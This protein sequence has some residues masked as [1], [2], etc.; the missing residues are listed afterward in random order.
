MDVYLDIDGVL[1]ANDL[2]AAN[3]ANEFL[4]YVLTK[5]P[6]STY[7]LTTHCNGDANTP[8][9]HVGHL[10]KPQTQLLLKNIKPTTWDTAKTRGI[11]FSRP[12]LWFDDDL[13][14]EEKQTLVKHGVLENWVQV[15]L[16]KDPEQLQKFIVSF[17]LPVKGLEPHTKNPADC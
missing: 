10:F 3:Y 5:F 7:W 15:D 2:N 1:V 16:A 17:P 12:F 13:F 8:I 9:Q 11:N 4:E 6:D 14:Y